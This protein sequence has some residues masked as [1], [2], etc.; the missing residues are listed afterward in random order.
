MLLPD[1]AELKGIYPPPQDA[2]NFWTSLPESTF[3]SRNL[4]LQSGTY[5]LGDSGLGDRIYI[6][7]NY[8]RLIELAFQ[9]FSSGTRGVV[10]SGN[11]GR[12]LIRNFHV[13]ICRSHSLSTGIG[14]S[15]LACAIVWH[16]HREGLNVVIKKA[17][18]NFGMGVLFTSSIVRNLSEHGLKEWDREK[19]V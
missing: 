5:F 15:I 13:S 8:S 12:C 6:R 10:V 11:P 7:K 1:I 17:G 19:T 18:W 9:D 4:T 3:K 16:C 14:K 2:E